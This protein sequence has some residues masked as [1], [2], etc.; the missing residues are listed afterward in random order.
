M[1]FRRYTTWVPGYGRN[2]KFIASGPDG[3]DTQWTRG[4]FEEVDR[5]G[6]DAVN[7]A[8]GIG[9][10]SL[11][12]E[13]QPWENQ[14]LGQGQ[15]RCPQLRCDRLVRTC[16]AKARRPEPMIERHW[17][18]MGEIDK[19]HHVKL[20]V[21]EWGPWYRP[22][23]EA[24]SRRSPGANADPARR[25]FQRHDPGHLE[26]PSRASSHGAT[27]RNSSIASTACTWHMRTAS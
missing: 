11:C 5:K 4:F 6:K 15:R 21:D 14:R 25:R 20:V 18:I 12:L 10:A 1:E 9:P 26:S 24:H 19:E 23:S 17:Q 7:S 3:D 16:C 27:A 13:S 8:Y 2:L 22:G